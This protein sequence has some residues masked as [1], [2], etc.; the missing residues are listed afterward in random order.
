MINVL[1]TSAGRRVEL[2]RLFKL[3]YNELRMEGSV[4]AVDIDP[5]A[6]ALQVA[7]RAYIVPRFS[8]PDY[9]P[10]LVKICQREH[11]SLVFP[12]I[13]P[14]IVVLAEHREEIESTG[15]RVLVV[16]REAAAITR[17]KWLTYKF[18][19]DLGVPTPESWLPSEACLSALPYPVFLKPRHGSAGKH[20]SRVDRP[21]ELGFL[22]ERTPSP[23]IQEFLPGPE[24]TSDVVSGFDG[25][26]L[27]VVSRQRIE[28]RAG[29]VAKGKTVYYPEIMDFCV[30]IAQELRVIGPITIQCMMRDG[31][32]YFTEIN[33]R[34]GG[35][36]PLSVKAGVKSPQWLL[37]LAAG[38][39]VEIPPLGT[40]RRGLFIT[41]FDESFFLTEDEYAEIAGRRI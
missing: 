16:S 22:L 3:A 25:K 15:A 9:V 8:D 31:R 12:L 10:E 6:P 5:L 40:Y 36:A 18:F 21:E 27:G 35:G 24:I 23:M 37:S 29:E 2:L 19:R 26:V 34:F 38:R 41:R 7:D 39:D 11:V 20:T 28:V 14:D 33:A 30:M 1:F 13:D 32:P 17:D 4:I